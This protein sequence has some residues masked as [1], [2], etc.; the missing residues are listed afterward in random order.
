MFLWLNSVLRRG[1]GSKM[2]KII[3]YKGF[4]KDF[5]CRGFQFEVGK[6]YKHDGK[7]EACHS[8][9]HSCENPLD[10][11]NY[12]NVADSRFAIVE[13]SGEVSKHDEDSKIASAELHI[14]AELKLPE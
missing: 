13:V 9:F 14:K 4:D 2:A 3:A 8:G 5:K 12:Y 11:L 7:V 6:D 10:V 1:G